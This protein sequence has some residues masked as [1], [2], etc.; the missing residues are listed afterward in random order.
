MR[1]ARKRLLFSLCLKFLLNLYGLFH[2]STASWASTS[3]CVWL[4]S[5]SINNNIKQVKNTTFLGIVIDE[6]LT[7]CNH[8]D[9]LFPGFG[10]S[11]T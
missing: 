4:K 7:W 8:L 5:I 1:I 6:F 2:I 10:I 11:Q 9:L 3:E